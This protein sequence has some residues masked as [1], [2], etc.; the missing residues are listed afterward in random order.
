MSTP[1]QQENCKSNSTY[2]LALGVMQILQEILTNA[3][4]MINPMKMN[5][6]QRIHTENTRMNI[7]ASTPIEMKHVLKDVQGM[8]FGMP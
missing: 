2:A 5:K 1:N 7:F 8:D 6:L 4:N 3:T